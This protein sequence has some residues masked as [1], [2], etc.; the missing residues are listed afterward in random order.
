VEDE[1]ALGKGFL[2]MLPL[3]PVSN[4]ITMSRDILH[5]QVATVQKEIRTKP[6]NR[7][8]SSAVAEVRKHWLGKYLKYFMV[9]KV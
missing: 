8:E 6:G 9:L 7:P 4:I 2:R 5:L 1:V 3:S